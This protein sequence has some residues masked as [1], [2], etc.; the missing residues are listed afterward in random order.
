VGQW[1]VGARGGEFA[2]D[3]GRSRRSRLDR[4]AETLQFRAL[5]DD[6]RSIDEAADQRLG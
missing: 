6:R 3:H 2:Q 1:I 4:S 5:V